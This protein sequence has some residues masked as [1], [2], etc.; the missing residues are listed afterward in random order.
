MGGCEMMNGEG[1]K[2][3]KIVGSARNATRILDWLSRQAR[4]A[5]LA[6]VSGALAIN[7]STCLNILHTLAEDGFVLAR[8]K[9]YA[10]GPEAAAF[11]YR[12]LQTVDDFS[13]VQMLLERFSREHEVNVLIWRIEGDD[14]VAITTSSEPSSLLTVNVTPRRRMPML[15][16]SIGRIVAAFKPIEQE[17]LQAEFARAGWKALTFERF[18][19]QAQEARTAGYAIECGDVV[20]GIHAVAAPIISADGG[21]DRIVSIYALA[22]DLPRSRIHEMGQSIVELAHAISDRTFTGRAQ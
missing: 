4:P 2:S 1:R 7:P 18:M 9:T 3:A 11:A 14:A 8:D 13:R 15:N 20:E 19:E 16:G 21:L 6:D 5:R 10:L 12:T 22:A 17:K